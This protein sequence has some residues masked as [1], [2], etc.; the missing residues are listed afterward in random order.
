V[1]FEVGIPG[2]EV[3]EQTAVIIQT[4]IGMMPSLQQ[5]LP[6]SK[7]IHFI[8]FVSIFFRLRDI[9]LLMT[10]RSVE[11]AKFTIGNTNISCI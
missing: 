3:H 5:K 8:D 4:K 10:G 7:S 11:I 9:S 6:S 2:L 1:K